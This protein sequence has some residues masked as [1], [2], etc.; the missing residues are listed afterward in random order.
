M[1][2]RDLTGSVVGGRYRVER[3]LG[4]GGMGAVWRVQ[5]LESLQRYALKTLHA[6]TAHDR[7]SVERFLREARAAAALSSKYVVK[8]VDA[9][10]GHLDEATLQPMPFL[11]MELLTGSNLGQILETNGAITA[12]QLVWV[13]QQVGRALDLAHSKGI[14]HRDLKPEN[15]FISLDEEGEP[16]TKV[17]DF[18]IAKVE[19]FDGSTA[20]GTETGATIGTP[21][22]MAPEQARNS[23]AVVPASDQWAIALIAFRA[24]TTREYFSGAQ[25]TADLLLRI[26]NDPLVLPS[27]RLS[28]LP[29]EFDEWFLRSCD[30]DPAKRW[31]SVG[32]QVQALR[33]ALS[34]SEPRPPTVVP[35]IEILANAATVPLAEV[36]AVRTQT[37]Q[38]TN[39]PASRTARASGPPPS[40]A[41]SADVAA[42]N[43]RRS[44]SRGAMVGLVVGAV[45]IGVGV[46]LGVQALQRDRDTRSATPAAISTEARSTAATSV[47]PQ[48][49]VPASAAP[50]TTTTTSAV[51]TAP[52]SASHS[53]VVTVAKTAV[54]PAI[55]DAS[56]VAAP[57]SAT[58]TAPS[59]KLPAGAPCDRNAECASLICAAF[60]CQ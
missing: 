57:P 21:L 13:L 38:T 16:I 6:T 12:E 8:I 58:V 59:T 55:A 45:A 32:A 18:G 4:S 1:P 46:I 17:C 50:S 27:T 30:R 43:D 2:D 5:H 14:V 35:S 25:S 7:M 26:V 52:V 56:V 34:V 44:L 54:K 41:A 60:Q 39:A 37:V 53:A 40:A 19:S 22:Y 28:T 48:T 23:A 3:K 9:Q 15:I 29:R 24:L 31:P 10:M 36:G 42:A 47:P 51:V 49:T 20:L 11:V 33:Q